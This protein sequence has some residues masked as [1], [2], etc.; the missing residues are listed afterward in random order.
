M[1]FVFRSTE[2]AANLA[3]P[4]TPALCDDIGVFGIK[5]VAHD[6]AVVTDAAFAQ[7]THYADNGRNDQGIH[8]LHGNMVSEF[9]NFGSHGRSHEF[10]PFQRTRRMPFSI[11]GRRRSICVMN[12][13]DV[14]NNR[15]N[16]QHLKDLNNM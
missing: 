3:T 1:F 5:T 6:A 14:N 7:E 11:A 9:K 12:N 4:A 16:D 13:I 2:L 10:D 8:H 15:N